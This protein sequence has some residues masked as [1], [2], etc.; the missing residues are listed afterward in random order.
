MQSALE[1]LSVVA[2]V[3]PTTG[4]ILI[5]MLLGGSG[6][7]ILVRLLGGRVRALFRRQPHV[8]SEE[9]RP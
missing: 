7:M 5:Q 6:L 3:D 9:S 2:Y 8:E 4:G 1:A